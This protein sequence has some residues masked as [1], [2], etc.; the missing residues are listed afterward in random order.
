MLASVLLHNFLGLSKV[1]ESDF[2]GT[3]GNA[4]DS[5]A[6]FSPLL[7]AL[8]L[9]GSAGPALIIVYSAGPALRTMPA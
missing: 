3:A 2:F 4:N 9:P 6:P 8:V 1:I 7:R 5:D